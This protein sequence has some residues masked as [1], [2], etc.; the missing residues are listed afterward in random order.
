MTACIPRILVAEALGVSPDALPP[1]DLPVGRLAERWLGY[2]RAAEAESGAAPQSL[3]D[4]WTAALMIDLAGQVPDLC[5]DAILAALP[6]C[7]TPD[8]VALIAAGPLED[9]LNTRAE[10]VIDRIEAEAA[11]RPRLRLALS[12]VWPEGSAG[13]PVWQR[14]IAARGDAPGLDDGAD[15]PD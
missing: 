10:A 9:L 4:F 7:R 14:V 8:E 11:G 2:L 13:T 5:L 12:G 15:L 6:L 1:G 3:P